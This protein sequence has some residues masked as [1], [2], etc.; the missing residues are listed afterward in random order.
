M[1]QRTL[2]DSP[3]LI[4]YDGD[5]AIRDLLMFSPMAAFALSPS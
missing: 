1:S 4:V 5:Q 3:L 2:L